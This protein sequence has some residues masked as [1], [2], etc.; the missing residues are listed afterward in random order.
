MDTGS[1]LDQGCLGSRM[2]TVCLLALDDVSNFLIV[3]KG[4]FKKVTLLSACQS[5]S[6]P[7]G[8]VLC[9]SRELF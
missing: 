8:I 1:Y 6:L 7:M 4:D 5:I 9:N 3:A 2:A